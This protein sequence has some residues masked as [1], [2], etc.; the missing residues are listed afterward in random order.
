MLVT[1]ILKVKV[2]GYDR[3]ISRVI[4]RNVR[5]TLN[6]NYSYSMSKLSWPQEKINFRTEA[7]THPGFAPLESSRRSG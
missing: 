4:N 5:V 7:A 2:N 6:R 1:A 3:I